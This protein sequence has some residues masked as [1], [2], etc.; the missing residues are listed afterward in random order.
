MELMQKHQSHYCRTD[1]CKYSIGANFKI[2][3]I[4]QN[5]ASKVPFK[6]PL[7]G[8]AFSPIAANPNPKNTAKR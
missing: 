4:I 8:S 3:L 6:N 7:T 1:K 5:T 2:L